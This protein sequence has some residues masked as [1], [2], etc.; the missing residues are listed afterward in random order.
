MIYFKYYGKSEAAHAPMWVKLNVGLF[1]ATTDLWH[2]SAKFH[3]D[4]ST[5]GRMTAEKPVFD[6]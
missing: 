1:R 2:F 6:S 5:F 4:L 3:T